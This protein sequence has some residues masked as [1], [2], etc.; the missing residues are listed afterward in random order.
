MDNFDYKKFIYEGSLTKNDDTKETLNENAPGYNT[1]KFGEALPT[2]ESVKAA[3]EDGNAK[4][5]D[6]EDD[7]YEVDGSSVGDGKYE[8]DESRMQAKEKVKETLDEKAWG[9]LDR[10]RDAIGDDDYI[11]QSLMKAMSTDD[12]N[13][14]LDAMMRDH[15]DIVTDDPFLND[16]PVSS[17][18]SEPLG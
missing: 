17:K 10:L 14:Y 15:I 12:A 11:I 6:L 9:K 5:K 13:L 16:E 4:E 7:S 18:F 1:R 8:D 2:L 3:Y